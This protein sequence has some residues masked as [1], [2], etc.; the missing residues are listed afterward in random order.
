MEM[1]GEQLIMLLM[2]IFLQNMLIMQESII[3]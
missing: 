2:K 1:C 3:I